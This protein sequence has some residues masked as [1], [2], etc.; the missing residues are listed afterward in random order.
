MQV[1]ARGIRVIVDNLE[2]LLIKECVLLIFLIISVFTR[3]LKHFSIF[4]KFITVK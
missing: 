4:M 3:V 1:I 2:H